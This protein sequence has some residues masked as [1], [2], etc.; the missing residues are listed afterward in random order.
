MPCDLFLKASF[1]YWYLVIIY[2]HYSFMQKEKKENP[3][4]YQGGNDCLLHGKMFV[5]S[6]D[7]KMNNLFLF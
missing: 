7:I 3:E 2:A 4:I 1:L 6:M 5:S